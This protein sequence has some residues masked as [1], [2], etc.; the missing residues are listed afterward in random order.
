MIPNFFFALIRTSFAFGLANL[1]SVTFL[2]YYKISGKQFFA[3][4]RPSETGF[5][6]QT[7]RYI[8]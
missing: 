8:C 4:G 3:N 1:L 7:R 2:F 6:K 5:E